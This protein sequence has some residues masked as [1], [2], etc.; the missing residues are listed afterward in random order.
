MALVCRMVLHPAGSW[1]VDTLGTIAQRVVS[2]NALPTFHRFGGG[3]PRQYVHGG[4]RRGQTRWLASI[5]SIDPGDPETRQPGAWPASKRGVRCSSK[6][7]WL[8]RPP[9]DIH[10]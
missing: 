8:D 3:D 6:D 9:R 10:P 7:W 4:S 1:N 5:P 2:G